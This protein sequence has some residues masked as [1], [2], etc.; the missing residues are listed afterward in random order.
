MVYP[1]ISML[2]FLVFLTNPV[3]SHSAHSFVIVFPF[4]LQEVQVPVVAN[5]PKGVRCVLLL[6]PAP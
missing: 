6:T 1:E 3:P 2:I 5:T 4:P